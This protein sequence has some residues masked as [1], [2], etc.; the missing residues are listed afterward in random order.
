MGELTY[1]KSASQLICMD[2]GLGPRTGRG[3]SM[4]GITANGSVVIE[5]GI[6]VFSGSDAL[7]EHYLS[8]R[9]DEIEIIDARGKVVTPGLIDPHTHAVFA[10]SRENE[11]ELRLQGAKY[12]DILKQGG[13]ILNTARSTKEASEEELVR[14]SKVRLDRFLLHGVTTIEAK[15]GYGLTVTDEL[16]QLRAARALNCS[17]PIDVIST[18]MGAHA[19]PEEYNN[20][21]E[22][23]VDLVI[24]EMLPA[25][26]EHELAEFCDVFCE[27]GIFS[28]AQSRRILDA[29]GRLG[30]K[31]KI[32][33]DE[34]AENFGGAELAAE[35]GAVSAEHLL[36]ASEEGIQALAKSGTIAVLLPGTALFLMEQAAAARKM[37]AAGVAV[38]LSTDCNPGSSPT[39]S[40][41]LI[42]NAACLTMKM[43]PAEVLTA[44]TINAA[45]AIGRENEIGSIE[46]GKQG[47]LVLFDA[48]N[49]RQLQYYYGMNLVHTVIKKGQ[50]VVKGG[51]LV[52]RQKPAH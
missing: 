30:F 35:L 51:V 32:H 5:D 36:K 10:G 48:D 49:Y 28:I 8:T 14:Q 17:H 47:D 40:M 3:M 33:A 1:V 22:G 12:I 16:K 2:G 6:I 39:V 52:D 41:P 45:Y 18:F 9:Q 26:A 50:V 20:N 23:Y 37:I 13:G 4:L 43:T 38:A 7:A 24:N 42:M 19:V 34:I 29:A 15:S 44:S 11:L 21:P 25:V 31:L 27:Q 46:I